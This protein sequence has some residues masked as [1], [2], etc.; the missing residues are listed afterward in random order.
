LV[1]TAPSQ[2][3]IGSCYHCDWTEAPKAIHRVDSTVESRVG[4]AHLVGVAILKATGRHS[5]LDISPFI[6]VIAMLLDIAL[7]QQDTKI[8]GAENTEL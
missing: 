6:E 5:C 1:N 4:R 7:R 8:L 2:A 3:A